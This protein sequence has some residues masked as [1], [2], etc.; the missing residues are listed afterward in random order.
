MLVATPPRRPT[1]GFTNA[2]AAQS[3]ARAPRHKQRAGI[4]GRR[5]TRRPAFAARA[6]PPLQHLN[7]QRYSHPE[8]LDI[9]VPEVRNVSARIA[10][11][12]NPKGEKLILPSSSLMAL[13][14]QG[15]AA[16]PV[17][18]PLLVLLL[19]IAGASRSPPCAGASFCAAS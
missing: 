6:A 11:H 10:K 17:A 4:P 15:A 16:A 18:T 5:A 3:I 9:P 13:R 2:A 19:A 1:A 7:M 8:S 12:P 14:P